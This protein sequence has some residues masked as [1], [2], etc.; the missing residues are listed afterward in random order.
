MRSEDE[1]EL[2]FAID[3]KPFEAFNQRIEEGN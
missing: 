3:R 2:S 1:G